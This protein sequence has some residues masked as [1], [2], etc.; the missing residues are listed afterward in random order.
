[1]GLSSSV[2]N[3]DRIRIILNNN[4][5]KAEQLA[6]LYPRDETVVFSNPEKTECAYYEKNCFIDAILYAYN[7]HIDL[8]LCPEDILLVINLV[9]T[10][11]ILSD[12][13]NYSKFITKPEHFHYKS[14]ASTLQQFDWEKAFSFFVANMKQHLNTNICEI[15]EPNFSCT[16]PL[17]KQVNFA[18]IMSA[19]Q[20]YFSYSATMMCGIP[21]VMLIGSKE[22]W[23][24]LH[25]KYV[26][27]KS[28]FPELEWWYSYFDYVMDLFVEMRSL[29]QYNKFSKEVQGTERMKLIWSKIISDVQYGSFG[30]N[31]NGWF[32][33]F[34]PYLDQKGNLI[35]K[36]FFGTSLEDFSTESCDSTSFS[37]GST[38]CP[39]EIDEK[40]FE[41][42]SGFIGI[43]VIANKEVKPVCGFIIL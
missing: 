38:T 7:N 33:L 42:I 20:D 35:P 28:L 17:Q 3:S 16:T 10:Q 26:Q 31:Y 6:K 9:I 37:F 5:K 40:E 12:P 43:K 29:Q 11:T 19:F 14:N 27:M 41:I 2:E 13:P 22:D 1:M 21:A 8:Q 24:A 34:V 4:V 39:I 25:S 18:V 36:K 30:S 15:M 32:Q 23:N